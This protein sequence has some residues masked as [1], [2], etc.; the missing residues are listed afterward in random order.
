MENKKIKKSLVLPIIL[1]ASVVVILLAF[2]VVYFG[3]LGQGRLVVRL[4]DITQ[5]DTT[6]V[7]FEKPNINT[8]HDMLVPISQ[9]GTWQQVSGNTYR[10]TTATSGYGSCSPV[11]RELQLGWTHIGG[12]GYKCVPGGTGGSC[13]NLDEQASLGWSFTGEH[14]NNGNPRFQCVPGGTH[15]NCTG[16]NTFT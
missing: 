3:N 8:I 9:T 5:K 15:G 10:C 13:S 16:L 6:D 12:L 1:G 11:G 7:T 14:D 2:A 4:S